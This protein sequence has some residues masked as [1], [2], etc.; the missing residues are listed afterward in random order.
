MARRSP[1]TERQFELWQTWK[2]D[3]TEANLEPLLMEFEPDI[4]FKVSE[5]AKA[6]VPDAA[7]RSKGR[8]LVLEGLKTYNPNKPGASSVR[9]WINWRLKKVRSFA[10]QN[11]NFGRIPE[12][13]AL[14]I[15]PFKQVRADLTERFGHPPDAVSLSEALQEINPKYSWSLAE[16]ERMEKELRKDR[17]ASMSLEPDQLPNLFESRE[18]DILRYIYHDLTP[19]EKVVYEYTLGINGKPRLPAKDIAREMKISGPKVS[20]LRK[21]IDNKMRKRGLQ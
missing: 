15:T 14:Q 20:R 10:I 7:I 13:R 5:F 17:M 3:P 16:V 19:Q 4:E 11:Q 1:K 2:D 6:P 12:G 9:T 18:R 21:S 8:Q